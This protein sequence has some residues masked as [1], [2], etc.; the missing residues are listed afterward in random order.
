MDMK[1]RLGISL[2][3]VCLPWLAMA[4]TDDLYFVPKKEKKTEA[5]TEVR[6]VTKQETTATATT[7]SVSPGTTVVVKDV[8]GKTRDIDEYNRRYTSRDNTFS[9][10]NDTLYIEEKPYGERGEWVNGFEGSQDDY[11]YAMRII[12]FRSP[13]Y[14]IPISS[15][16]YWDVVYGVYP[17]WNWN[18]YDDGLYAYVFPTFSNPLWWDWRWSW[19]ITGPRWGFGWS[20]HSPWY[21][22]GWYSSYWYGGYWSGWHAGY[23]DAWHHPRPYW[24]GAGW[25]HRPRY[26]DY[27][28]TRYMTSGGVRTRNA[29]R[30]VTS[31]SSPSR[32]S[33][34]SISRQRGNTAVRRSSIGRVVQGS[35]VRGESQS[36]RPGSSSFRNANVRNGVRTGTRSQGVYTRPTRSADRTGSSYN[37]PSSTRRSV[38]Y[39]NN[40]GTF[41]NNSNMR[42]NSFNRGS[43]G[44]VNRSGGGSFNRGGGGVSRSG[45]GSRRR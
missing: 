21:Y 9:M 13:A 28:P 39:N 19:G 29:G 12:R 26:T 3:A 18:V 32:L 20:W 27:R 22:S 11:E 38:N 1:T 10:Q 25:H 42:N 2:L 24:G 45:G 44:S 31:A 43:S 33:S 30:Y 14:A 17:S 15:P 40:R 4:Q 41:N 23:W 8:A 16:L 5:K 7:T 34:G 36:V 37:R 35:G 6:R